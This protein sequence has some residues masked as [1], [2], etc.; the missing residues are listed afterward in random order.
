M[1]SV[2]FVNP[3]PPVYKERPLVTRCF[4]DKI[5]LKAN[6]V[7]NCKIVCIYHSAIKLYVNIF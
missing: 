4:F 6:R 1:R 2:L 7:G 3:V 5:K